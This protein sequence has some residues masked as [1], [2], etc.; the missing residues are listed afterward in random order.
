MDPAFEHEI[1]EPT[2]PPKRPLGR[3]MLRGWRRRCPNCGA[4]PMMTGFLTVRDD[5]PVC[6][7]ELHHQR[8]DDGPAYLT[9]LAVAHIVGPMLGIVYIV[10]SPDPIVVA[11]S[12]A[13]AVV[14]L[15]LYFLPRLKGMLVGIQWAK[16]M[17]G[18]GDNRPHQP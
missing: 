2:A 15:S 1:D 18:F 7:E 5:C 10:A 14:A 4:G 8:A 3:S 17:G 13:I 11:V 9:I 12:L 6:D 16:R